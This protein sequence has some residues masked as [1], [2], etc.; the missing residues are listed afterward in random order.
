M[1]KISH[2]SNPGY[3]DHSFCLQAAVVGAGLSGLTVAYYL[4]ASDIIPVVFEKSTRVGGRVLGVPC[5]LPNKRK[6]SSSSRINHGAVA[7]VNDSRTHCS[8]AATK[9]E[10]AS[11][12][13]IDVG[14]NSI[15]KDS[16]NLRELVK[17]LGLHVSPMWDGIVLVKSPKSRTVKAWKS[18]MVKNERLC[19]SGGMIEVINR[20]KRG[21][22]VK[23]DHEL[24][25]VEW[26]ATYW[27]LSFRLS[28]DKPVYSVP[29]RLLFIAIPPKAFTR[30]TVHNSCIPQSLMA[31]LERFPTK[32]IDTISFVAQFSR[33]FWESKY[34]GF[35]PVSFTPQGPVVE[36]FTVSKSET[37]PF[38]I[39]GRVR[40][41]IAKTTSEQHKKSSNPRFDLRVLIVRHLRKIFG[42]GAQLATSV[43]LVDWEEPEQENLAKNIRASVPQCNDTSLKK[44]MVSPPNFITSYQHFCEISNELELRGL[45]LICPDC[46]LNYLEIAEKAVETA[47]RTAAKALKFEMII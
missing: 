46:R 15:H 32:Y 35:S 43:I 25:D 1:A 11:D 12:F 3:P 40:K 22:N 20:L 7:Y 6:E 29:T 2:A 42:D 17:R 45:Y 13:M 16:K 8:E 47:K 9:T 30:V 18:P 26:C 33:P 36:A 14:L 5:C 24:V 34:P 41:Q 38:A 21:V 28:E 31:A 39:V 19:P 27:L 44:E 4:K 37:G 10:P 23:K